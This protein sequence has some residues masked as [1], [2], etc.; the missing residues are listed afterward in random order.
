MAPQRLALQGTWLMAKYHHLLGL[1]SSLRL[2]CGSANIT[3][4]K[5][6]A[7]EMGVSSP[8]D[9]FSPN[10]ASVSAGRQS[11]K[12]AIIV[13]GRESLREVVGSG[14]REGRKGTFIKQFIVC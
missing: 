3:E 8:S 6:T 13:Q 10:C 7:S 14:E 11:I 4:N 2:E 5:S 9:V 12:D 1:P